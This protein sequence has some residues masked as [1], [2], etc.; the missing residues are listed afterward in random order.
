MSNVVHCNM[1]CV[2]LTSSILNNLPS[3]IHVT[4]KSKYGNFYYIILYFKFLVCF[5]VKISQSNQNQ[6]N[7]QSGKIIKPLEWNNHKTTR[8]EQYRSLCS[9]NK[10]AYLLESSKTSTCNSI[11]TWRQEYP[12]NYYI[13]DVLWRKRQ[14]EIT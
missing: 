14:Y 13:Q 6:I 11:T 3:P 1:K 2:T 5:L 4:R 10:C 9:R 7:R 12:Q 8:V